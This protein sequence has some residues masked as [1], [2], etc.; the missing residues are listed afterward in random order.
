MD[1][2][3]QIK[4]RLTSV[5]LALKMHEINKGLFTVHQLITAAEDIADFISLG[6]T[7]C[8]SSNR[9]PITDKQA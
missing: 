7:R 5:S 2:Q 3:E 9:V 4:I 1:T 6:S 8:S